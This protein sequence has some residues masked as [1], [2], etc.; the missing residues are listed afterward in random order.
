MK[1]QFIKAK[2]EVKADGEKITVVASDETLDRH[3]EVL[4]IESW[5]LSKFK[6]AP[7][8]LVDHDHSVASIVGKW[9]KPRIEQGKLLMDANFH[10]IT[11]LA[12]AT[13]EMVKQGYLDTVSVGF[14]INPPKKEGG[15]TLFELIETSWVTVPANPSA[16]VQTSLK[17]LDKKVTD[18]EKKKIKDF[19]G[20]IEDSDDVL[21]DGEDEQPVEPEDGEEPETPAEPEPEEEELGIGISDRTPEGFEKEGYI[22]VSC[23]ED[24]DE[25]MFKN[26]DRGGDAITIC[27]T[28][29]ISKLLERSEQ[30]MALT[31]EGKRIAEATKSAEL[32]RVAFKEAAG[33]ISHSLRELNKKR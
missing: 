26:K 8:M 4:P 23:Q 12:R 3:G 9:L 14:I 13:K 21:P 28:L 7:R 5:D 25:W 15:A 30:L 19:D 24:F 27:D 32:V 18:E 1:K 33:I 10:D 31:E 17:G 22:I 29:F 20:E 11:E 16:R 2:V 6:K